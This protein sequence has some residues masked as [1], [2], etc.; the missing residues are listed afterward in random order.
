MPEPARQ[1]FRKLHALSAVLNLV[2][3]ADGIALLALSRNLV[4]K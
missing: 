4:T 2:L 3:L 1:E